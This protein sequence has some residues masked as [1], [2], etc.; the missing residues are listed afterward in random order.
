MHTSLVLVALMGPGAAPTVTAA[1][2]APSWQASYEAARAAGRERGKPLVIFIGSGPAGWQKLTEEG[3]LTRRSRQLLTEGYV[4]VYVDQA[5]ADG[6]KLAKA[7]EVSSG[8]GLVISSRDAD[9]QAFSYRGTMSQGELEETL[10]KYTSV[11]AVH[12][13][14]TLNRARYSSLT[15]PDA[16]MRPATAYQPVVSQTAPATVNYGLAPATYAAP[17][18][19]APPMSFGGFGGGFSGGGSGGC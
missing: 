19:Y 2:E 1:P 15:Y 4:C 8:T 14:E 13:T 9:S 3:G 11:S 12:Q 5:S 10:Q 6:R 7:F 17:M 18:T 16:S